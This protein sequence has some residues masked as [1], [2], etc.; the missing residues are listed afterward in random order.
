[1]KSTSDNVAITTEK[2]VDSRDLQNNFEDVNCDVLYQMVINNLQDAT[3]PK[4]WYLKIDM[5]DVCTGW[6]K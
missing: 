6:R 1:M 3:S 2:G 5:L 4:Q